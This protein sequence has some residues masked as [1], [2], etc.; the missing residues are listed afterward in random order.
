[1]KLSTFALLW[2][3]VFPESV[4]ARDVSVP[5]T[6]WSD[7]AFLNEQVALVKQNHQ[8]SHEHHQTRGP[9]RSL[10]FRQICSLVIELFDAVAP[11][12]ENRDCSCN[13]VE[14]SLTCNYHSVTCNNKTLPTLDIVFDLGR[15]TSTV[16]ICQEF[17]EAEFERVCVQA[18][19]Q[20]MKYDTCERV[21]MGSTE[22]SCTI[23]DGGLMLDIDCTDNHPLAA[24]R[25]CQ[26]IFFEDTCLDFAPT[27]S[28][29]QD[30]NFT[31]DYP[32]NNTLDDTS[33]NETE[34]DVI[35]DN[36]LTTTTNIDIS[37][38]FSA[39]GRY[40]HGDAPEDRTGSNETGPTPQERA[41]AWAQSDPTNTTYSSTELM[42]RYA[43]A[44]LYFATNSDGNKWFREDDWLSY[45]VGECD[46][47]S[48]STTMPCSDD[49]QLETLDLTDN[50]L[51]GS[52]V[53]ELGY[54]RSLKYMFLSFNTL[55]GFLP[56]SVGDLTNLVDLDLSAT[57]IS[58]TIPSS[59]GQLTNLESLSFA[60]NWL[61][62]SIPSE[63]G[64][65]T[66]IYSIEL[67]GNDLTGSVPPEVCDLITTNGIQ[68]FVDCLG[69]N[70]TCGCIC[71]R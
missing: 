44:T 30:F 38:Q 57:D 6:V 49:G 51:Y 14:Q 52:L 50:L 24:T 66:N 31:K 1:M 64:L 47:Y 53:P 27:L 48:N 43:M 32:S 60:F 8:Q 39:S 5:N 28:V 11:R 20:D 19:L 67:F 26:R 21:T 35:L 69:V 25:G 2:V 15:T 63:L 13:F 55:P 42:Q 45:R 58:G 33:K 17:Q 3:I 71:R 12:S 41:R 56:S 68:L 7:L 22:C 61:Y 9:H 18:E 16:D 29:G 40:F 10:Q 37:R 54:L 70:C 59:L 4:L 36:D 34:P 62:G 23:C 65:L 46:W